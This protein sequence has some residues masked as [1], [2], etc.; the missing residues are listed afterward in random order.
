MECPWPG[1]ARELRNVVRRAALLSQ[2][3]IGSEHLSDMSSSGEAAP[4]LARWESDL[5]NGLSLK[6]ISLKT[7]AHVE[8]E[9]I[10]GVLRVT[11]GNKSQAARL[12]RIDYKTLHYKLKEYGIRTRE[13]MP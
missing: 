12:L 13:L 3:L 4:P 5:R 1:N 10:Q 9:V 8:K 2:D 11:G 6:E 7:T